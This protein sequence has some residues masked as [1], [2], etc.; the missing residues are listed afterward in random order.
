MRRDGVGAFRGAI[1]VD[2]RHAG[3]MPE[4]TAAEIGSEG[5][6]DANQA[7]KSTQ[8]TSDGFV[9]HPIEDRAQQRRHDL[10]HGDPFTPY[11]S[12]QLRRVPDL[13]VGA[14]MNAPSDHQGR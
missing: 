8:C 1:G 13:L 11:H 3:E 14:D 6:P 12:C 5:L 2:E 7:A 10:Q 9:G 4:P